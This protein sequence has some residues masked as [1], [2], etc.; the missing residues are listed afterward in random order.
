MRQV[1]FLPGAARDIEEAFEWHEEQQPGLGQEFLDSLQSVIDLTVDHPYAFP[2]IYRD[3]RRAPVQR[4][5][6]G[7]FYRV[8]SEQLVVV[9]CMHVRRNPRSWQSRL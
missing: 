7:L 1:V 4:F 3:A 6:Y 8:H 5:P 2:V 9:A